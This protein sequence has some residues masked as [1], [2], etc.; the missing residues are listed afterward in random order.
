FVSASSFI[1]AVSAYSTAHLRASAV[2]T[3]PRKHNKPLQ[4]KAVMASQTTHRAAV[5]GRVAVRATPRRRR[6][7]SAHRLMNCYEED[8]TDTTRVAKTSPTLP[9]M[10]ARHLKVLRQ[11][12]T[13]ELCYVKLYTHPRP[14]WASDKG[15]ARRPERTTCLRRHQHSTN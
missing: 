4:K 15:L 11:D 12:N 13:A 7:S 8:G 10:T 1:A 6:G 3:D 14:C 5:A 9:S 2:E